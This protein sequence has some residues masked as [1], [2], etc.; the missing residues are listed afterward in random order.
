MFT[1]SF[2]SIRNQRGHA[3]NLKSDQGSTDLNRHAAAPALIEAS[4]IRS[5][6]GFG[7][8]HV[9]PSVPLPPPK[10]IFSLLPNKAPAA[11]HSMASTGRFNQR[12]FVHATLYSCTES[13]SSCLTPSLQHFLIFD[14]LFS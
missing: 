7:S 5:Q 11:N 2:Q 1:T 9:V 6:F 3:S 8:N 12:H 4:K 14:P 13:L 10:A